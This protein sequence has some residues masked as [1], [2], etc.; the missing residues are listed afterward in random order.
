M[1]VLK[2]AVPYIPIHCNLVDDTLPQYRTAWMPEFQGQFGA[3][4]VIF[5][6][7]VYTFRQV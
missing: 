4:C 3:D 7:P 2:F 5:D 6:G 1:I